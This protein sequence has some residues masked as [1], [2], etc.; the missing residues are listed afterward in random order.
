MLLLGLP[1]PLLPWELL[2]LL[3]RARGHVLQVLCLQGQQQH[4]TD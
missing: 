1:L 4:S 3:L 2:L